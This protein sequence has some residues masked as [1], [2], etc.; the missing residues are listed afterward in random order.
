M[1]CMRQ[2]FQMAVIPWASILAVVLNDG[3]ALVHIGSVLSI[4][5]SLL[6]DACAGN[7]RLE[8]CGRQFGAYARR[9]LPG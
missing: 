2:S 1:G 3:G 6:A 9:C 4:S 8:F 7:H 5:L